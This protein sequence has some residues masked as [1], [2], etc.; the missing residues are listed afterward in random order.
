MNF[1]LDIQKFL[2]KIVRLEFETDTGRYN[3]LVSLALVVLFGCLEVF[4]FVKEL[5]WQLLFGQ[6]PESNIV[7]FLILMVIFF[8]LCVFMVHLLEKARTIRG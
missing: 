3:I 5:V 2:K 6:K 4:T 1:S 7:F 8:L